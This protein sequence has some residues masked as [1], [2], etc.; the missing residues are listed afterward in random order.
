MLQEIINIRSFTINEI[1]V[2]V[3]LKAFFDEHTSTKQIYALFT[4]EFPLEHFC[5]QQVSDTGDPVLKH[6]INACNLHFLWGFQED[7]RLELVVAPWIL[8]LLVRNDV[9]GNKTLVRFLSE[10]IVHSPQ[11]LVV[12]LLRIKLVKTLARS[13]MEFQYGVHVP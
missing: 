8:L 10:A 2:Q 5:M 1:I 4:R 6:T 11:D 3:F 13:I 7:R 9:G 12:S